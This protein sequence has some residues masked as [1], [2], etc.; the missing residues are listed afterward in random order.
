MKL[1]F[2][3]VNGQRQV[4]VMEE[5]FITIP[6]SLNTKNP[7][8]WDVEDSSNSP[9]L[10][11][12]YH[13][14]N[15]QLI[16]PPRVEF[17][18]GI[19]ATD[20]QLYFAVTSK[21]LVMPDGLTTFYRYHIDGFTNVS[22]RTDRMFIV[23]HKFPQNSF[24]PQFSSTHFEPLSFSYDSNTYSLIWSNDKEI[25]AVQT[26][27]MVYDSDPKNTETNLLENLGKI[28]FDF[29]TIK[30]SQTINAMDNLV[31]SDVIYSNEFDKFFGI[32]TY[33]S[34]FTIG[35]QPTGPA[36]PFFKLHDLGN[37]LSTFPSEIYD[38]KVVRLIH[39]QT[40]KK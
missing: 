7:Q 20:T 26:N 18:P 5:D 32:S 34:Q 24:L 11:P 13:A 15:A 14:P 33:L 38:S 36:R 1:E 6:D 22:K 23:E 31:T 40:V 35:G 37:N 27:L 9:L 8:W 10:A 21:N 16:I 30:I 2:S 29:T 12:G 28:D 25:N 3:V 4:R 19:R 39:L 17:S